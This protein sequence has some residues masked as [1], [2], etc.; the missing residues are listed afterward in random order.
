MSIFPMLDCEPVVQVGDPTRLVALNSFATPDE[1]AISLIEI[2][3]D[4][5]ED[6]FDVTET[7]FLDW[8]FSAAGTKTVTVRVTTSAAP[9]TATF[10]LSVVTSVAD[11]LWA[12]DNDLKLY[13]SGLSEY[14]AP[15]RVTFKNIHRVAKR[16]IMDHLDR[17]GYFSE[18]NPYER[19]AD[20]NFTVPE[21]FRE[22]A[23]YVALSIIYAD[24]ATKPDDDA[25]NKR[26][27]YHEMAQNCAQRA[28]LRM[29]LDE[30][31]ET[32]DGE[33]VETG[34]SLVMVRR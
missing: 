22:W 25:T 3:P 16:R 29:D 18:N 2:Q 14:L 12:T 30:D 1:G 8:A 33:G 21:E 27:H 13:E 19:L 26:D 24:A 31:G 15:G 28:I 5:G 6:F 20:E 17:E 23:T 7:G 34:S 4:T 11:A 32:D 10:T 9:T